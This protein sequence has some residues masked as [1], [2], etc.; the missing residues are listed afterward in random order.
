MEG[1]LF[2]E[3]GPELLIPAILGIGEAIAQNNLPQQH[4]PPHD[5]T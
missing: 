5:G 4:A 2:N 1:G 3:L